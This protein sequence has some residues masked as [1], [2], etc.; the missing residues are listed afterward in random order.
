MPNIDD[1]LVHYKK[2][3][4]FLEEDL[5]SIQKGFQG[6]LLNTYRMI[7]EQEIDAINKKIKV[8][9]RINVK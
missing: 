3:I 5:E 2:L 9:E 6:E 4:N 1:C 7:T 8:L